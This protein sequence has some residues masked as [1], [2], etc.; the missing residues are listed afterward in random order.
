MSVRCAFSSTGPPIHSSALQDSRLSAK[1]VTR[2]ICLRFVINITAGGGGDPLR[3][4]ILDAASGCCALTNKVRWQCLG[5]FLRI[6]HSTRRATPV[7][8]YSAD[9][10]SIPRKDRPNAWS[11]ANRSLERSRRSIPATNTVICKRRVEGGWRGVFVGRGGD[12]GCG[13]S[14]GGAGVC[15]RACVC[16]GSLSQ[17]RPE[18]P[19]GWTLLCSNSARFPSLP[20]SL[21]QTL[22]TLHMSPSEE[23]DWLYSWH[24]NITLPPTPQIFFTIVKEAIWGSVCLFCTGGLYSE[25]LSSSCQIQIFHMHAA[26]GAAGGW[27]GYRADSWSLTPHITGDYHPLQG[28]SFYLVHPEHSVI[29]SVQGSRS[30]TVKFVTLSTR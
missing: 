10:Y 18:I 4:Q 17:G 3:L 28:A 8:F 16:D 14:S 2:I 29:G 13:R 20:P 25:C 15:V 27:A 5:V 7:H 9:L 1:N 19:Q 21:S 12:K 11:C 26:A 23:N 6:S 24:D 30:P 22:G